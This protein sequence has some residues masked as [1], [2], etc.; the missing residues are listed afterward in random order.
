MKIK[1]KLIA[2]K[3]DKNF[4]KEHMESLQYLGFEFDGETTF[5]R[6]GSIARFNN[7]LKYGIAKIK[8]VYKTGPILKKKLL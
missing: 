8:K 5:I 3:V 6:S 1:N 7:Q 4:E 2:W